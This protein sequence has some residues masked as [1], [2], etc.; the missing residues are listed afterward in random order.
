LDTRRTLLLWTPP[1]IAA[2]DFILGVVMILGGY[3]LGAGVVIMSVG[4]VIGWMRF[5]GWLR[6]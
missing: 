5:W 2:I 1:V 3:S 6:F 4:I